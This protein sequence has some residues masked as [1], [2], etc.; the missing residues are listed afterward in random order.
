VFDQS[1]LPPVSEA[2]SRI[3]LSCFQSP[4][5]FSSISSS[6]YRLDHIKAHI[7]LSGNSTSS[8]LNP[9]SLRL[10][11]SQTYPLTLSFLGRPISPDTI[12][13]YYLHFENP[14]FS[15]HVISAPVFWI[16]R[17]QL[18]L[19]GR[20]LGRREGVLYIGIGR[21]VASACTQWSYF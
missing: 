2:Y 6:Y 18:L 1:P 12:L 19:E 7:V 16:Y 13:L 14:Y 4:A 15:T 10:E 17:L 20:K 21:T 3:V 8:F 9:G 5:L 11:T